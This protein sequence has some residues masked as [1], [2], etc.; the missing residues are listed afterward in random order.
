V[1]RAIVPDD[2]DFSPQVPQEMAKEYTHLLL[3]NV[4]GVKKTV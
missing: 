1:N 4:V 2:N 3:P